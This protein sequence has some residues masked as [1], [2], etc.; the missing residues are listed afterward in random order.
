M[1]TRRSLRSVGSV[2]RCACLGA[3][4]AL[5]TLS[6]VALANPSAEDIAA[7]RSLGTDGVKLA[8]A[9]DCKAAIPKL[10]A[11]EKLFH[12]PTTA[13]RLGECQSASDR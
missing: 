9:G 2:A 11:A 7:A 12:A 4:A 5:L 13:D 1:A 3:L 6:P 10:Q 8:D